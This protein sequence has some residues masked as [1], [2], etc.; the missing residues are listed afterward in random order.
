MAD[1]L[2][3]DEFQLEKLELETIQ[4]ALNK[5][6]P[7]FFEKVSVSVSDCPD[8]T[9][10]P[11]NLATEG[12]GGKGSVLIDIGGPPYLI[13]LVNREKVY[14]LA[15]IIPEHV[16]KE[17]YPDGWYASGAGAG[18]WPSQGSNCEMVI[19][20]KL[21][22]DGGVVSNK[23]KVALTSSGAE[24]DLTVKELGNEESRC[25]LLAN[26]LVS[27]GKGK[28]IEIKCTK[29]IDKSSNFTAAIRQALKEEFGEEKPVGLGGLFTVT[30]S[31]TKIHVMRD[32]SNTPLE[33]DDDVN[34]WLKF[35]HIKPPMLFQSV[36]VSSDPGLDLRIEHAHGWNL[37]GERSEAG[38]YHYDD[39]PDTVE[40][41]GIYA[42]A[43]KIIRID[44]PQETHQ[45]GRD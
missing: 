22:K 10:Q 13:P 45:L 5:N 33:S 6:L 31:D 35:F 21:D 25:A 14:D 24:E 32:F 44:R 26:L 4:N 29:R 16:G 19:N 20:L 36:L 3:V 15:K 30:L 42:V 1:V 7:K 9:Q 37:N 28:I 12:I 2:P 43:Q 39:M 23:S 11:Y 8:L 17:D 27:G 34:N 41:H 38:H 18:P 40:Y